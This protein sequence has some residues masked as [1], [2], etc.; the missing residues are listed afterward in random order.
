MSTPANDY[1]IRIR[2]LSVAFNNRP[3]L[4]NIT[5]DLP[6]HSTS[7]LLG[8]SGSGKTTLLRSINRLNEEIAGFQRRGEISLIAAD[9]QAVEIHDRHVD[10]ARLRQRVGMVFQHPNPLPTSIR[11]NIIL[12]LLLT[13][14]LSAVQADERVAQSL[15]AV[16]LWDEVCDRLDTPASALS[17][18]QQQRL[19]LA[20]TLALEPEILLLDEP[21][22]SL[23]FRAT[24]HIE[25]TI[26]DLASRYTIV[27]VSHNP[28]QAFRLADRV[29][30]FR[31]GALIAV[32][33]KSMFGSRESF[34][35]LLEEL[36]P[37][38]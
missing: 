37:I 19:C 16:H 18:G 32:H 10:L 7:V 13:T 9:G 28:S 33:E 6:R 4:E 30:T 27:L 17:G 22:A 11:R 24:A 2:D 25:K 21:T 14:T 36:L 15:R 3:V 8:L 5:L 38:G 12:P 35:L 31:D 26:A 1:A 34:Q 23:D 29:A 20:R